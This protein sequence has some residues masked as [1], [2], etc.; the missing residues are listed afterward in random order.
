MATTDY[1]AG[2]YTRQL[3]RLV[4][5][6]TNTTNTT[7]VVG[8]AAALGVSVGNVWKLALNFPNIPGFIPSSLVRLHYYVPCRNQSSSGSWGGMYLEPQISYNGGVTWTSLGTCGYDGGVMT[9]KDSVSSFC[10]TILLDP[11]ATTQFGVQ[12]RIY[13]KPYRTDT[14]I[15]GAWINQWTINNLASYPALAATAPLARDGQQHFAHIIVEE[16][17]LVRGSV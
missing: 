13:A 10:N 8:D 2:R 4:D 9:M 7:W 16:L 14:L 17:A 15:S 3:V 5:A 1:N 12:I 11:Q 6:T